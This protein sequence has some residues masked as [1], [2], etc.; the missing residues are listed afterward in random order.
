M[1]LFDAV[2][3]G[4]LVSLLW[5]AEITGWKGM[6]GFLSKIVKEPVASDKKPVV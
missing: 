3:K 6:H 5:L 1:L 2:I 4:L